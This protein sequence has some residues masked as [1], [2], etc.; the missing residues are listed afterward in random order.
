VPPPP[1]GW[2]GKFADAFRGLFHALATQSSFLAHVPVAAT[3]V[4]AAA[5]FGLSAG[6][7]CLVVLAIGGVLAAEVFNTALEDLARAVGRYPDPGIRDALDAASA[8]VLVAVGTAIIVGI[9]IFG[10]R[11][12]ALL[13]YCD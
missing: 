7:W 3:A 5:W 1:R 9:V 8:G 13:G 2:L 10:P 4:A 12:L 11:V 6:E